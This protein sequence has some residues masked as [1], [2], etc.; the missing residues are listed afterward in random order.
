V[1]SL[2]AMGGLLND[3]KFGARMIA[4]API[5]SVVV[6]ATL[7]L[8]IGA[9][10]T[11][12]SVMH[13]VLWRPLPYPS[14]E[15]LV[16]VDA[17]L[18]AA[19]SAGL[20][21]SEAI[22][23]RAQRDLF[24]RFATILGPDASVT[25]D[26]EMQHVSSVLATDDALAL[27]GAPLMLG[28]PLD[29]ARDNT[30]DGTMRAVVVSYRLWERW[31]GAD[32]AAIGRHIE[33]N[34]IDVEVAGVLGPDF[35][36]FV[37]AIAGIPDTVDVWL[38][39]RVVPDPVSRGQGPVFIARLAPGVDADKARAGLEVVARRLTTDYPSAYAEGP[40][41]LFIEPL[42]DVLTRDVVRPLWVLAGAIAL[43]LVIGCVNIANLMTA[44]ARSRESELAVRHALGA[45]R[46]RLAR[47][48][49]CEAALL[50]TIGAAGG[51]GLAH[52]G[53]ALLDWLQPS[54]LPR[55]AT[56]AVTGDV[57]LFVAAL[58][59]LVTVSFGLLPALASQS[60]DP[61]RVGR[62]APDRPGFRRLQR[63]MVVAEV[64]LSIVPLFAAGLMLR[65]FVNLTNVPFGFNP[66]NAV[67]AQIA[68][69]FADF[70]NSADL[71]TLLRSALE[72]VRALPG[73]EAAGVGGPVPFDGWQQT[74]AYG[75]S[76]ATEFVSRATFQ[77]A[78]PGYLNALGTRLLEGRD[79][80]DAD[81]DNRRPVVIVDERIAAELWPGGALGQ[82][83][84]LDGGPPPAEYEVIGVS[85]SLRV[86]NVRDATV[87]HVF[88]PYHVFPFR[89][90]LVLRG[91]VDAGVLAPAIKEAVESLGTRR[92]V[93][94][95]VPLRSYVDA[96]IGDARFMTIVLGGFAVAAIVLTA[97]GLYGTLAY[98]T[99][100]RR[101]EF[102]LRIA[103]GATTA[104]VVRS[105][106]REGLL[107]AAIGAVIGLAGALA[108]ARG[109]QALLYQ[110]PASDGGTLIVTAVVVTITALVAA[111]H[112]A[113]RAGRADPSA[114]LHE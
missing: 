27:F 74:D 67:S 33:V 109:I 101:A 102:G 84:K 26:G 43:V 31:L 6:I 22:D 53:V 61:L 69:S 13:A 63:V 49:F 4:R 54:H 29:S 47:Q 1:T 35:R 60:L 104:Q 107:L 51:F 7:A 103:L 18:G 90:G 37:P 46:L 52:A 14:A 71:V 89:P 48:F 17:D 93:F 5:F 100:V 94:D 11:V 106:A 99:S 68:Y 62:G 72:R 15:R 23:L 9:S 82:R 2:G 45:G 64:A 34:N 87:R 78:L 50:G 105:V 77:V 70:R 91:D 110:V 88:L 39:L 79:F 76:G 3:L 40:L 58:A 114:V 108:A 55:Q 83:L 36:L 97:V 113:W 28:R 73:V 20:S 42:Q 16:V 112:P 57:A 75:P 96:A 32:P 65:T 98:L 24:D 86:M 66:D 80:S 111:V 38:P 41:R 95:I 8:V 30:A 92:P 56:V 44:R 25:I 81:I 59:L 12:F 19:R 10:A 21:I 85:E